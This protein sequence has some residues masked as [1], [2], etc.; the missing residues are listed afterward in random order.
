MY[1]KCKCQDVNAPFYFISQKENFKVCVND[2]LACA[3][4]S[5]MEFYT[6]GLSDKCMLECPVRNSIEIFKSHKIE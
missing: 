4:P 3:L 2:L 5:Y 6:N 1:E